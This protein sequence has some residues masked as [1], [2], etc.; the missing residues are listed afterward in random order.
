MI[1]ERSFVVLGKFALTTEDWGGDEVED[2]WMGVGGR[3]ERCNA[4]VA[5][6]ACRLPGEMT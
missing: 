2:A 3:S 1:E 5:A 6:P 4:D